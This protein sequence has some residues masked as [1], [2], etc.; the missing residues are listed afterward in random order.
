MNS[1]KD[2]LGVR[3]QFG[4]WQALANPYCAKICAGAGFDFLVIDCEHAPNSLPLV[5]QQLQAIAAYQAEPVVRLADSS[6]TLIKH[7][8]DIGARTLLVPMIETLQQAREVVSATRYPPFGTRGV[9]AGLARVSRWNRMPDYLHRAEDEICLLL[10]VESRAG[11]A[12]IEDL[13]A[14]EGVHGIFVGPADLAA[15]MGHL[16]N[17]AHPEVVATVTEAIS[18]IAKAGTAAGVLSLNHD[19]V[20]GFRDAGASFLAVATDVV[21]L[22]RGAEAAIRSFR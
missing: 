6:A 20:V 8:L 13:S 4:L 22:A 16:G 7:Y 5:L 18:R 17:P 15:D 9:G 10:Q 11:L 19:H 14:L 3:A 1:F 2:A 21:I 12:L